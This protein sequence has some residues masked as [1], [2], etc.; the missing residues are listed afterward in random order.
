M[1]KAEKD[2]GLWSFATAVCSRDFPL[3]KLQVLPFARFVRPEQTTSTHAIPTDIDEAMLKEGI[4][5]SPQAAL[6]RQVSSEL[7]FRKVCDRTTAETAL[8]QTSALKG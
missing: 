2:Q 1:L 4:A 6:C 5:P 8:Q 7:E 3:L